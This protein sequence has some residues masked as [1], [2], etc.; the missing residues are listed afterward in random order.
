MMTQERSLEAITA[1]LKLISKT[2]AQQAEYS[3]QI[4]DALKNF[5]K[6][7]KDVAKNLEFDDEENEG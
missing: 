4:V 3:K 2:L 6:A 5:K 1:Q 7:Y